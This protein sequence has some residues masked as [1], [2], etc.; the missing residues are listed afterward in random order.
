MYPKQLNTYLQVV[1]GDTM[2]LM[3]SSAKRLR[4]IA[5]TYFNQLSPEEKRELLAGEPSTELV[6]KLWG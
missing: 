2:P 1:F 5:G 6:Q 4:S 3:K